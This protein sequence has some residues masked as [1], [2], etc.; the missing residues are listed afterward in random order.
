MYT[1]IKQLAIGVVC[2]CMCIHTRIIVAKYYQLA[3]LCMS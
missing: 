1:K 2:V 3:V